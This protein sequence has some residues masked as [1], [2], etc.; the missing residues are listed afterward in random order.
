MDRGRQ[1]HGLRVFEEFSAVVLLTSQRITEIHE[2]F[3]GNVALL[4]SE[5]EFFRAGG[6]GSSGRCRRGEC[7]I[8]WGGYASM[9]TLRLAT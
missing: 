8:F 7:G 6:R 5:F 9:V 1:K 3:L 2:I 4:A